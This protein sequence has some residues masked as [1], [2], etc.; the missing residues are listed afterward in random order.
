MRAVTQAV[1]IALTTLGLLAGCGSSEGSASASITVTPIDDKE[2]ELPET[3]VVALSTSAADSIGGAGSAT[4]TI[5]SE[6]V[7]Q[8]ALTIQFEGPKGTYAC[9]STVAN[10]G[11]EDFDQTDASFHLK[12]VGQLAN[13]TG[14]TGYRVQRDNNTTFVAESI[15]SAELP[16]TATERASAIPANQFPVTYRVLVHVGHAPNHGATPIPGDI[17]SNECTIS[18][19]P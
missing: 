12:I 10:N 13:V 5:S 19:S 8:P 9:G 1:P 11:P 18:L 2:V 14:A 15:G 16:A 17:V 3:V 4:V 7:P 6:D